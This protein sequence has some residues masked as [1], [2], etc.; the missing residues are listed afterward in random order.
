MNLMDSDDDE[1]PLAAAE[2]IQESSYTWESGPMSDTKF[3]KIPPVLSK[4]FPS[5]TTQI[6]TNFKTWHRQINDNT[7]Y[8]TFYVLL[9]WTS[10]SSLCMN[11][12]IPFFL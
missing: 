12:P 1:D 9:T 3:K 11:V 8:V 10:I 4:F 2:N 5:E 7:T 6:Q